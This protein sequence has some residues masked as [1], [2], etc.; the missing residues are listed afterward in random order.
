MQPFASLLYMQLTLTLACGRAGPLDDEALRGMHP[1]AAL[2]YTLLPWIH[3]PRAAGRPNDGA[4][5]PPATDENSEPLEP[6]AAGVRGWGP[7]G[8]PALVDALTDEQR[9]QLQVGLGSCATRN[10]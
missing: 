7:D 5:R 1:F 4:D 3:V 10:A 9:A 8:E 2:L 6:G